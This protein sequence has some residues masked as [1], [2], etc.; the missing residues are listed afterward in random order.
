M[1]G[2]PTSKMYQICLRQWAVSD[3][4]PV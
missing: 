1:G 3:T 4:I 2:Q